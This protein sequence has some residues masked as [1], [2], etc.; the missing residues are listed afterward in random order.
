MSS[1]P[2]NFDFSDESKKQLFSPPFTNQ[3]LVVMR[4]A[5]ETEAKFLTEYQEGLD[6]LAEI[7]ETAQEPEWVFQ[8]VVEMYKHDY[9]ILKEHGF[10]YVIPDRM[11]SYLET[12]MH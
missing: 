11:G 3:R 4:R 1:L 12:S 6:A 10:D 7:Q 2:D 5:F 8:L 9:A